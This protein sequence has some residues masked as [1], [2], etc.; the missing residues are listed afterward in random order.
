MKKVSFF[1]LIKFLS[2]PDHIVSCPNHIISGP[3]HISTG[4]D[5]I[6]GRIY[7]RILKT[8]ADCKKKK[9]EG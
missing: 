3:D 1:F 7:G 2:G 4:Q 5:N 9:Q 8:K 6:C